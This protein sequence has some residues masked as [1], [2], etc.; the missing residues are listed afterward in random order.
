MWQSMRNGRYWWLILRLPESRAVPG[1]KVDDAEWL[2][3]K[4]ARGDLILSTTGISLVC[5]TENRLS[6]ESRRGKFQLLSLEP[7]TGVVGP[8][9]S[10]SL[11]PSLSPRKRSSKKF[12]SRVDY[13]N[14]T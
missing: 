7:R 13:D 4:S 5:S 12:K 14:K 1:Q 6:L 10:G 11:S 2:K 9:H 3:I 8:G